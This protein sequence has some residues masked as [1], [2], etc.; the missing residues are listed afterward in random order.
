MQFQDKS[1]HEKVL[2]SPEKVIFTTI[3]RD[4]YKIC[5]SFTALVLD[6]LD[7]QDIYNFLYIKYVS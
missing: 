6:F 2:M 5:E 7:W 4:K 1:A 3:L